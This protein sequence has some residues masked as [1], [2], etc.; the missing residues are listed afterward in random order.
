MR[1]FVAV[2]EEGTFTGAADRLVVVQS[3]IS[4]TI[5]T[6]ERELGTALFERTTRR[7]ELTDA[8][9]ALLPE[10]LRTI[11][12]ARLAVDAVDQV[13]GGIRGT[14]SV[15]IMQSAAGRGVSVP[16]LI[17]RF[18][19]AH[20]LVAVTA[21]HVGGSQ[22]LA[23]HV[24]DGDLDLGILSLP[25]EFPGLTLTELGR[26][27][28]LLACPPWHPLARRESVSVAELVDEPFVDAPGGWGT[29]LAADQLFAAAGLTRTVSFEVNDTLSIVEFVAEGLALALLP[30]SITEFLPAVRLVPLEGEAPVFRTLLAS[31]ASRRARA[32][33]VAFSQFVLANAPSPP[34]ARHQIGRSDG[35]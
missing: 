26:E 3:A 25:N 34:P 6:L 2:A 9:R 15:G 10:A 35:G 29:R 33:V 7:V 20:P 17:A 23:E 16:R 21:R 13:K 24:R 1:A 4:S 19:D 30:R 5:R 14:V 28:M 27:P 11:E 32:A 22:F 8:G 18:Q 31:S 12:A